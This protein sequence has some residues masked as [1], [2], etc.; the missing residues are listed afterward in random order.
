MTGFDLLLISHALGPDC[1]QIIGF[2]SLVRY[3]LRSFTVFFAQG[4]TAPVSRLIGPNRKSEAEQVIVDMFRSPIVVMVLAPVL[5]VFI[6]MPMLIFIACAPELAARAFG[7]LV[8]IIS[9]A[10]FTGGL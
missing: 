8:P 6:S 7:Y 3:L 10:P 1:I 5:F 9:A 2:S 4:A